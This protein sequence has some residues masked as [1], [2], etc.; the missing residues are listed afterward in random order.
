MFCSLIS[1]VNN[2][3]SA[4]WLRSPLCALLGSLLELEESVGRTAGAAEPLET[5]QDSK[6]LAMPSGASSPPQH[7]GTNCS[8]FSPS[9]PSSAAT[10]GSL[11]LV[12]VVVLVGLQ[13][14]VH[15]LILVPVLVMVSALVT[16][17]VLVPV[18]VLLLVSVQVPVS[19]LVLLQSLVCFEC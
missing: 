3:Q 17:S 15:V 8:R 4:G 18:P 6:H 16:V 11:V 14:L 9:S 13:V 5:L 2:S 7:R 12:P 1:S 10:A 19:V